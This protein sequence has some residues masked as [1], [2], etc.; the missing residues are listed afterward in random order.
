M[1]KDKK[2]SEETH[3]SSDEDM[4]V[5]HAKL[6]SE[7]HPPTVGFLQA[8]LV[9]VFLFGFLVFFCS[10]QLAHTTNK[11]Q[12]HP[13]KKLVDLSPEEIAAAKL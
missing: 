9:F 2:D 1:S 7:K 3:L 13:P 12:L 4:V 10:I 11:F 5:V 8:P 6:N